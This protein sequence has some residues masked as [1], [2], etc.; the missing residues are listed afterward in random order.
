[1]YQE[2]MRKK[3]EETRQRQAAGL[4]AAVG[5]A[6]RPQETRAEV[7]P[8][9]RPQ[10]AAP[11]PPPPPQQEQ[12][13]DLWE[14]AE[15]QVAGAAPP[16]QLL[17]R[18]FPFPVWDF[19][20]QVGFAAFLFTGGDVMRLKFL[21]VFCAIAV[22]KWATSFAGKFRLR[23]HRLDH[24]NDVRAEG[25]RV[26]LVGRRKVWYMVWKS[27]A[28]FFVSIHP[29]FRVEALELEVRMDGIHHDD[30]VRRA[31]RAEAAAQ[32]AAAAAPPV[33]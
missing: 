18:W 12:N 24:E 9:F 26:E 28:T 7:P 29:S 4:P 25:E 22:V 17:H 16:Q 15:P 31:A 10:A 23:R 19:L 5:M 8:L 32:Q 6:P 14:N 20:L 11:P 33:A 27:V 21:G 3:F 30:A 1:M 13:N 2:N